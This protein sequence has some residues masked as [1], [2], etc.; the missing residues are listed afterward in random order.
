[1]SARERAD[2]ALALADAALH[3]VEAHTR[4]GRLRCPVCGVGGSLPVVPPHAVDCALALASA[5]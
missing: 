4:A 3:A 1:M 2:A 5:D